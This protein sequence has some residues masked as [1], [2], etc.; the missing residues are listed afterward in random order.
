MQIVSFC[1]KYQKLF[2]GKNTENISKCRL[3]KFLPSMQGVNNPHWKTSFSVALEKTIYSNRKRRYKQASACAAFPVRRLLPKICICVHQQRK[4]AR[5]RA[6]AGWWT[7]LVHICG[8][9]RLSTVGFHF[10]VIRKSSKL[11]E[12][13][14]EPI[15]ALKER[16][17]FN[18]NRINTEGLF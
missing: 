18:Y 7:F 6:C 13:F 15:L 10:S 2:S 12:T 17:N 3:L 11:L 8:N 1:I 5:L 16:L 4:V 14:P 9:V